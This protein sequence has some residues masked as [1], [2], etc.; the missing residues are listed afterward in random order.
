[1]GSKPWALQQVTD[2]ECTLDSSGFY[3]TIH[4]VVTADG[5]VNETTG[6][7]VL[8]RADVFQAITNEPIMSFQGSASAVRK[9]LTDLLWD[10]GHF[11]YEHISYI[12]QEL[13]RAE[14]TPDFEQDKPK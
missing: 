4:R 3:V 9:H 8:V 2:R 11:S 10:L 14:L 5:T 7:S 13:Q 12:G 1:M 6:T